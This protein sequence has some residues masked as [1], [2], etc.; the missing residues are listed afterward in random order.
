MGQVSTLLIVGTKCA[1][2]GRFYGTWTPAFQSKPI[3]MQHLCPPRTKKVP[4]SFTEQY[5]V[6]YLDYLLRLDEFR[7][8]WGYSKTN[9]K[10]GN[11]RNPN[12][13]NIRTNFSTV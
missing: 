5:K 2:C 12:M 13:G 11:K 3:I 8:M 6:D 4:Q 7:L 9:K 10:Y 1:N